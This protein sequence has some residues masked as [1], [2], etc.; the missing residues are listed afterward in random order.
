MKQRLLGL[1]LLLVMFA[2]CALW[3][4]RLS[5]PCDVNHRIVAEERLVEQAKELSVRAERMDRSLQDSAPAGAA[6][7]DG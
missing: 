1:G 4:G 6:D 5:A 7:S 3:G 2:A